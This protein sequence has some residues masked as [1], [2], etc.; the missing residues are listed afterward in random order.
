[1]CLW[2][3][4]CTICVGKAAAETSDSGRLILGP[5]ALGQNALGQKTL[6]Q[7]RLALGGPID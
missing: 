1:M 5:K 4:T 6:E 3:S 7:G 2:G